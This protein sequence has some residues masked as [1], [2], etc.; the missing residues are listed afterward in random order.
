[1]EAAVLKKRRFFT[2]QK[3][4]NCDPN[5]SQANS[6]QFAAEM[7]TNCEAHY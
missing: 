1:M 7:T 6:E 5:D 3:A 4:A 2:S